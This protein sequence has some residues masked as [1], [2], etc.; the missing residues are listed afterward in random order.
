MRSFF[1]FLKNSS[2]GPSSTIDA[3]GHEDHAV[4]DLT[5]KA[6]FVGHADH[7]H[8][9]IGQADHGVEHFLDHFRIERG[10]RLVEQHDLGL[11]AQRARDG[12]AL[13]LAAGKLGRIFV[14]LIEDL[15]ARQQPPRGRLGLGLATGREPAS[16]R[17]C[18]SA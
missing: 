5:G 4:G 15:D 1:G 9:V 16:A 11:H 14:G 7:G 2:G 10:G 12:D 13:L 17:A 6:H 8:A 18:S 3:V